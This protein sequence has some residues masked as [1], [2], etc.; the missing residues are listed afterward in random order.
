MTIVCL[1][2]AYHWKIHANTPGKN[3]QYFTSTLQL[4]TY[5]MAAD[6]DL[7]SSN[8]HDSTLSVEVICDVQL[9]KQHYNI[10]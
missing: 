7:H 5:N 9:D 8:I 4:I 6:G 2:N 10:W 3:W 1:F